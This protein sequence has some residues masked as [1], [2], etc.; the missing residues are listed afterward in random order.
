MDIKIDSL[1]PYEMLSTNQKYVFSMVEKNGEVLL[2]KDNKPAYIII[3]YNQEKLM[4][5]ERTNE[6]EKTYTLH[7]A[8][9]LVLSEKE[10]HTMHAAKL[11]DEIYERKLYCQK[12]GNKAHYTQ[13]RARCG[14]YPKYFEVL[15]GNNIR[16]K[17]GK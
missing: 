17:G 9:R 3:K 10:D 16:L 6:I 12:D 11:S 15:T 4:K 5:N 8:M 14:H 7:D 1:I 13:I 2:L